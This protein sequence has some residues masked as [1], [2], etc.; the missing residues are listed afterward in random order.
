[1]QRMNSTDPSR[2]QDAGGAGAAPATASAVRHATKS[3]A[4]SQFDGWAQ[5]YDRS[6]VQHLL[7]QPAYRMF[8]EELWRWRRDDAGRFDLLDIGAGTGTWVAM[9][10]GCPLPARRIIGLDYARQM[11]QVAF[12]K[13]REVGAEWPRFVNADSEHLPFP[14]GS[15]DVVTCSNSFHHY[16]HQAATVREMHRVLRPGGRLMLIDGFRDNVIGW[17]VFDVIITT[18]ESTPEARVFHAPWS[19][20]RQYFLDAGFRDIVQRKEGVLTPIFLTMGTA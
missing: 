2:E 16:P 12:A 8:M 10:A 7:F 11:C 19:Q 18:G 4:R 13:S 3:K 17:T 14:D 15:F 20:M 5:T 9:V 1:M 6:I